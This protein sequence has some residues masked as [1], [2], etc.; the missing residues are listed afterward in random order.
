[1]NDR[2]GVS[3][4]L[5][6]M[7]VADLK[8]DWFD[9]LGDTVSIPRK[10]HA[11]KGF[12]IVKPD[13]IGIVLSKEGTADPVLVTALKEP[14]NEGFVPQDFFHTGDFYLA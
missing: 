8:S 7:N 3:F 12:Q 5:K 13:G 10:L 14:Q 6:R 9:R 11:R 4:Y 2:R 1:M